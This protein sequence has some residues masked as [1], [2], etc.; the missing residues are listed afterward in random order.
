MPSYFSIVTP[1]ETLPCTESEAAEIQALIDRVHD[2]CEFV[3]EQPHEWRCT[4]HDVLQIGS[5]KEPVVCDGADEIHGFITEWSDDGNLWIGAEENGVWSCLPD[6]A[7]VKI[8]AL[9]ARK[10]LAFLEFGVAFTCSRA[11]PG[12]AGGTAFRIYPDGTIVN[13][14]ETWPERP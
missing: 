3:Q 6:A 4:T 13:R 12:S 14:V 11:V 10:G 8:G 5:Q 9:V 1:E 2:A 7:L